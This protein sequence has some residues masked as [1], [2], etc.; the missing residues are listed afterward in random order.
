MTMMMVMI[1]MT[2]TTTKIM[3]MM[4][5]TQITM[6]GQRCASESAAFQIKLHPPCSFAIYPPFTSGWWWR[7][8]RR[9]RRW[10]WRQRRWLSMPC[11]G[12]SCRQVLNLNKVDWKQQEICNKKARKS[13]FGYY[14]EI[15]PA[16]WVSD[17][18]C[19]S[20]FGII[21]QLNNASQRWLHIDFLCIS[22]PDNIMNWNVQ[23]ILKKRE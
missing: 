11:Q 22:S 21:H 8:R 19:V 5:T 23:K 9:R 10:R 18:K 14:E 12:N 16:M 2:T 7:R 17:M 6:K 1:A 3:M 20:S 13:Y 4:M 15:N